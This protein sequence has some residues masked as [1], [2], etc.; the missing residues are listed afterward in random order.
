[1][2]EVR[3]CQIGAVLHP[4]GDCLV[5]GIRLF[6]EYFIDVLINDDTSYV[7]FSVLSTSLTA[8]SGAGST[9]LRLELLQNIMF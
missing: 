9:L 3:I 6:S 8:V 5:R 1:M 4:A 7:A 2:I